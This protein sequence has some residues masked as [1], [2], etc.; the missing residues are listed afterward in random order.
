MAGAP[1][2]DCL[3]YQDLEDY[4]ACKYFHID[5]ENYNLHN[6]LNTSLLFFA[7]INMLMAKPHF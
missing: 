5:K 6:F 3:Y 7:S 4:L 1:P 2:V